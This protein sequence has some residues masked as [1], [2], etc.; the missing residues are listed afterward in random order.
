MRLTKAFWS[1]RFGRSN[2]WVKARH[3]REM[4]NVTVIGR[5][6]TTT[7]TRG[8]DESARWGADPLR[9]Q[10]LM[11]LKILF[12]YWIYVLDLYYLDDF[13]INNALSFLTEFHF[14]LGVTLIDCCRNRHDFLLRSTSEFPSAP[15][16]PQWTL[17][18]NCACAP[19]GPAVF[20]G[21]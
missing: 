2:Q 18:L 9:K 1:H 11:T 19:F 6:T 20:S 10:W 16:T 12:I 15:W 14:V 7:Y 3:W 13:F 8:W 17:Q 4:C 21:K 5:Q